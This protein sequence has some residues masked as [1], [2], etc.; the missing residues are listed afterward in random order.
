[1]SEPRLLPGPD[2]RPAAL[3]TRSWANPRVVDP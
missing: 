2:R 3:Q 1:M